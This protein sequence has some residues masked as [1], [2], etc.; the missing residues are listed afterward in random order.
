MI[1]PS[2]SD[3]ANFNFLTSW[4]KLVRLFIPGFVCLMDPNYNRLRPNSQ[5]K[6]NF[7]FVN[8]PN[9]VIGIILTL[10]AIA[11]GCPSC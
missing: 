7:R 2:F 8:T 10:S 9:I 4:R 6:K 3:I 1:F 11:R 5:E